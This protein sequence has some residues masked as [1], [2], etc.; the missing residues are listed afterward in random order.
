MEVW[1]DV[2]CYACSRVCGEAPGRG[3]HLEMLRRLQ[4]LLPGPH[5]RLADGE[6]RC[7]RCGSLVYPEDTYSGY[8]SAYPDTAPARKAR[9]VSH[10]S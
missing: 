2:K 10:K 7:S 8:R 9:P 3:E 1:T 5:C 6:L 4:L